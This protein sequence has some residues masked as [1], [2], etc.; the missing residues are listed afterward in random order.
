MSAGK[1]SALNGL[2]ND[3][4]VHDGPGPRTPQQLQLKSVL[5]WTSLGVFNNLLLYV[6]RELRAGCQL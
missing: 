2:N 6:C 3:L 4:P 5:L 1:A